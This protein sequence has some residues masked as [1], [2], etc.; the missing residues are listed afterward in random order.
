[1]NIPVEKGGGANPAARRD[2]Y[3]L[4]GELS[5]GEIDA[6]RVSVAAVVEDGEGRIL[7]QKRGDNGH[8]GIPGGGVEAG[9]SVS[10]AVAR[11]VREETGFEVEPVRIVGVYSAPE[12]RQILRYPDGNVVHYVTIVLECRLLGGAPA[13]SEET[14]A[15]DWRRPDDLPEPFVPSHRIRLEDALARSSEAFLR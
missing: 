14:A 2:P 10:G 13:L 6:I 1:V 8:W 9:E 12:L 5:A 3:P 11:E 4:W 7:L 15:I